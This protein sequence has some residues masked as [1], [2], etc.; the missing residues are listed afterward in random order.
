MNIS[1]EK[2]KDMDNTQ[3]TF[4]KGSSETTR[5]AY[6]IKFLDWFIGFTESSGSFMVNKDSSLEFKIIQSSKNAAILFYIKKTLGFGSISILSKVNNTHHFRV[7]NK[8]SLIIIISIFN[9][10][11]QL[12]KSKIKFDLFLKS[13]NLYY[14]ENII[15]INFFTNLI[16]LDS[17]WACGFTDAEGCF[18]VSVI[19][20][21]AKKNASVQV[22]Y[23]LSQ[24]NEKIIMD[25]LAVLFR[26]KIYYS[27]SHDEYNMCVQ[28]T[29]LQV[30]LKYFKIFKLKT[31]KYVLYLKW[32]KIYKLV[33]SQKHLESRIILEK[34]KNLAKNINDH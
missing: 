8:N 23:S 29:Y 7:R 20:N 5:T 3:E 30:V 22:R 1:S 13:F 9:G 6:D 19:E 34:I 15:F 31:F 14:N 26:G 16:K 33:I 12:E 21:S 24:K 17:A 18:T 10:F 25:H 28:L 32:L 2:S 11:L 27:A 4:L